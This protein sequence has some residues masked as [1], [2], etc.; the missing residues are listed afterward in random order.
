MLDKQ[1]CKVLC[2][3]CV[4]IRNHVPQFGKPIDN[5]P[6]GIFSIAFRKASNKVHRDVFPWFPRN[7]QRSQDSKWRMASS[8]SPATHLTVPNK[9]LDIFPHGGPVV[10]AIY[11]FN[12]F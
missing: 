6:D 5:Y 2:V 11:E 1:S 8:L 4:L 12:G 3:N 7:R 10:Q 9:L